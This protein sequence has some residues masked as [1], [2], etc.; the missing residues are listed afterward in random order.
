MMR[1]VAPTRA[2]SVSGTADFVHVGHLPQ[3]EPKAP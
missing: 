3:G 1:F 2:S